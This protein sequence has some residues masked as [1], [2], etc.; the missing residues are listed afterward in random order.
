MTLRE[1]VEKFVCPNTMI[2]LWVPHFG[3]H[4]LLSDNSDPD[5]PDDVGMNWEILEK[6]GWQYLFADHEVIGVT[7]IRC[8]SYPEAVNVVIK[9]GG[10]DANGERTDV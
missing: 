9:V 6:K 10:G 1:F 7:D 5:N 8:D 2:R 4:M 3:G